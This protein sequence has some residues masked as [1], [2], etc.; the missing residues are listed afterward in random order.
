MGQGGF[1]CPVCHKVVDAG[2]YG[3]RGGVCD[4]LTLCSLI[5]HIGSGIIMV[6]FVVWM[7][8]VFGKGCMVGV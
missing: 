4:L 5:N 2:G 3:V 7:V 1:D 8:L 6:V